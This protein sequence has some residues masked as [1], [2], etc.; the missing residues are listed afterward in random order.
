MTPSDPDPTPA[1]TP[2]WVVG[3][4]LVAG[5]VLLAL[6]VAA[7]LGGHEVGPGDHLGLPPVA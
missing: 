6:V 3:T 7:L 4:L 2:R 5:S 1:G